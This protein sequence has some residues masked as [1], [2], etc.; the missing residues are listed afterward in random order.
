M[1]GLSLSG[2]RSVFFRFFFVLALLL[3]TAV[4]SAQ[5]RVSGTISTLAG[6]RPIAGA[7]VLVQGTPRGTMANSEGDFTIDVANTDT[8]MFRAVGFKPQRLPLNR[9][10][11]SQII[12]QIYM[13]RDSIQLG[14][15]RIQEDRPD[16]T[17]INRALRNMRRPAPSANVVRRPPAPRPLFPIDTIAPRLPVPTLASPLSLIYEQ[18][19]RAGQERRKMAEIEAENK[20]LEAEKARRKYNRNFKDNKGYE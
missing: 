7:A 5:V 4:A 8:L 15:V 2:S 9:T 11:L 13:V 19:S 12:V 1:I 3:P 17:Q 14:E 16:R 18:F 10:G 6:R 20:A